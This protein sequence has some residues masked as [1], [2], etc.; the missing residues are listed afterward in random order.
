M[1]GLEHDRCPLFLLK[2]TDLSEESNQTVK[3]PLKE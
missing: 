1:G 3:E 2:V